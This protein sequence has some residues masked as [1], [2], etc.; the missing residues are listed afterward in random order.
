MRK[1]LQAVLIFCFTNAFAQTGI[2]WGSAVNVAA[3]SFGNYH[4]RLAADGAGNVMVLWGKGGAGEAYFS[5]W[6]GTAFTNPILL[7][8]PTLPVFTASWAGPDIAASGDS[9]YVVVKQTPEMMNHIYMIHSYDGGNTFS[10]PV[11]VDN[12]G[13]DVSRFPAVTTDDAG[14]PLVAFMKF[15]STFLN[16]RYVVTA[17]QDGGN[18]F[19]PDMQ[20][21]GFSG[22]TVCDCCPATI[23]SS[24]NTVA[25]LYRDNLNNVRNMWAGISDDNGNSFG[26]GI[27]L[28]NT[29]WMIMSCPSS[30]PEGVIINDTLCAVFMSQA[31]GTALSYYSKSVI[32]SLTRGASIPLT[33]AMPGLT[34]QN[35]P[36]IDHDGNE[37]AIAWRQ[38]VNNAARVCVKYM[39]DI[40]NGIAPAA[41]TIASASNNLIAN[42]DILVRQGTVHV[43][44]Q[45]DN[46]GTV[47]YR[48]GVFPVGIAQ[49][50]ISKA[51]IEVFPNPF[52]DRFN[53]YFTRP[54]ATE[55]GGLMFKVGKNMRMIISDVIGN[56]VAEKKVFEFP[57]AF[58]AT[59]LANGMYLL[60]IISDE[61]TIIKKIIKQ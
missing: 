33:G 1:V 39:N 38:T 4:P 44:W 26:G 42:T 34:Q 36:R 47:R 55:A 3:S 16:A 57:F 45:D 18:T 22:G 43:V 20:A 54:G 58:D 32:S 10:A 11:Q 29:N 2:Q 6:N 15:D 23:V 9:V 27:Q 28:D 31:S 49:N 35:Y 59:D 8:P 40:T 7:N 12:I 50:E 17:S 60:K 19:S 25:T 46:A 48:K 41:D 13:S 56:P 37:V 24:G 5:K 52:E 30:G 21:S 51:E 53:V 61:K 14:N